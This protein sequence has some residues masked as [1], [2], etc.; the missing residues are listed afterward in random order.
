MPREAILKS[1]RLDSWFRS[2][3]PMFEKT[4][5]TSS[6]CTWRCPGLC[7]GIVRQEPKILCT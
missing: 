1:N 3:V 5:R 7:T 4:T 6:R 2:G